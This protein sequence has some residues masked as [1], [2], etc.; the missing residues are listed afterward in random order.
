MT[1]LHTAILALALT[2]AGTDEPVLLDFSATWCGP[3][4]QM[5]PVID[6]LIAKGYP[7]RKLDYDKHRDLARK[8]GVDQIPCFVMTVDGRETARELGVVPSQ[9]LEKMFADAQ[10]L[11][12]PRLLPEPGGQPIHNLNGVN[13]KA[14]PISLPVKKADAALALESRPRVEAEPHGSRPPV[15]YASQRSGVTDADLI[16]ATVRLRVHDQQ[17]SGIG[18]GTIIDSREGRALIL[19][20]GHVFR[21]YREGDRIEVDLFGTNESHTVEGRLL[22][23]DDE[24]D[25]GLLTIQIPAPVKTLRVA[26]KAYAVDVGEQVANVGCNHGDDPTVRHNKVTAI[27]KYAGPDNIEVAGLPVQG[28]SGGGLFSQEGYVIGVCNAADPECNEGFYAA[29]PS[30]HKQLDEANLSFIYD[31]EPVTPVSQATMVAIEEPAMPK[32][33]PEAVPVQ[34]L[35]QSREN[36]QAAPVRKGIPSSLTPE[37]QRLL[38]ELRR[39]RN[40]GAEIVCIIRTKESADGRSEV[41]LFENASPQLVEKLAAEGFARR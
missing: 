40:Q 8:Y 37:E 12:R 35:M 16:A 36:G 13:P 15:A 11:T 7:V 14:M 5:D 38:E 28:R 20:C 30:I 31:I 19:T 23:F 27:D 39:R 24:C 6:G 10:K 26:P 22:S 29:L 18:T 2:G 4:R 21:E 33:M 25:V 17:G 1:G 41:F 34:H 32:T 9:Y 3:C